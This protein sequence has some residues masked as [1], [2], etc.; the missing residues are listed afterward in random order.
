[1]GLGVYILVYMQRYAQ[2]ML[3]VLVTGVAKRSGARTGAKHAQGH[4]KAHSRRPQHVRHPSSGNADLGAP[5]NRLS[6]AANVV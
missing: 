2:T 6:R 5:G 1:M 4:R 3:L